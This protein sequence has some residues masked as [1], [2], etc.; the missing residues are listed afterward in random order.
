LALLIL[1]SFSILGYSSGAIISITMVI[2]L[3]LL[4]RGLGLDEILGSF[5]AGFRESFAQGKLTFITYI[6][7]FILIFIGIIQA[8]NGIYQ[9]YID[10]E[11]GAAPSILDTLAVM[12][13][14]S[15]WYLVLAGSFISFGWIVD[16]Y[17]DR[18]ERFFRHLASPFFVIATGLLVWGGTEFVLN[19]IEV[20]LIQI[21]SSI[22]GAMLLSYS[23]IAL[24]RYIKRRKLF[25]SK[26]RRKSSSGT[27]SQ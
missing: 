3:Y 2:G 21:S 14:S 13:N 26:R 23:G 16:A 22:I 5:Y 7:A 4:Y 20:S 18:N 11:G 10:V 15:I 12:L 6:G 24:S 17:I 8:L 27:G 25:S 1:A 19:S 9:F